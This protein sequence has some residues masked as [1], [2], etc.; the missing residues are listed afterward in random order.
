MSC[1]EINAKGNMNRNKDGRSERKV[2]RKKGG[3]EGGG[4][5]FFDLS[6]GTCI[7]EKMPLS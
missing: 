7:Q 5:Y 6:R 4:K 3:T 1:L 2:E